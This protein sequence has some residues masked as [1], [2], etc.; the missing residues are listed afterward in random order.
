M[1]LYPG[2]EPDERNSQ[3]LT[4]FHLAVQ[5][6]HS[7]I[8]KKPF[9]ENYP[10]KEDEHSTIYSLPPPTSIL[11]LALGSGDPETVWLVLEN[12]LASSQDIDIAWTSVSSAGCGA[13]ARK[14]T[15][16]SGKKVDDWK[17]DE[18]RQLMM[19][20]GG[21]TPPPTP[22]VEAQPK[23]REDSRPTKGHKSTKSQASLV[24]RAL[25]SGSSNSQPKASKGRGRGRG[26]GRGRGN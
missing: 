4:A 19:T 14:I 18:I 20:F 15:S 6:G 10:P 3:G 25:A 8:I 16:S 9:F 1:I 12:G 11:T 7:A 17:L 5:L 24:P 13:E 23:Q 21:F 26:C 22:K 2:A